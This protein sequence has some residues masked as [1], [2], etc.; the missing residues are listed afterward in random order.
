MQSAAATV[1]KV[2]RTSQAA[3]CTGMESCQ[4]HRVRPGCWPRTRGGR[5]LTR[6]FTVPSGAAGTAEPQPAPAASNTN[7]ARLSSVIA[8]Q[9]FE[10]PSQARSL[11]DVE[12]TL[13]GRQFHRLPAH[14]EIVSFRVERNE[15]QPKSVG[16]GTGREAAIGFAQHH[17]VGSG[18]THQPRQATGQAVRDC[19]TQVRD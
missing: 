14:R 8:R 19:P 2:G 16:G 18:K 6:S 13:R 9:N 5:P 7:R 10:F 3:S 11:Q 15:V 12:E 4:R 1:R 17:Y